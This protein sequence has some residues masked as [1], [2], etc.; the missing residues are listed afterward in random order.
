MVNR[1]RNASQV[2]LIL[3]SVAMGAMAFA[4]MSVWSGIVSACA[5]SVTAYIEFQGTASKLS[6]Y[7]GTVHAMTEL[8]Q[9]W[10][11]LPQI[12][13]SVV[14][15]IDRLVMTAESLLNMEHQA[16][17]STSQAVKLLTSSNKNNTNKSHSSVNMEASADTA[18]NS[19]THAQH[20]VN[21]YRTR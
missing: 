20:I 12:D 5:L 9:W 21:G 4:D 11:T 14:A 19:S 3:A 6:R 1:T 8:V 13:R 18:R 2:L 10:H 15:N 7:S 17:R 16:W